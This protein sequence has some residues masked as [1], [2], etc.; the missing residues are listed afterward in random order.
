M[1]NPTQ[2]ETIA[3]V[4][5]VQP[6]FMPGGE[7]PFPDA[8]APIPAIA[9]PPAGRFPRTS[10]TRDRHPDA[11]LCFAAAHPPPAGFATIAPNFGTRAPW[12]G[13]APAGSAGASD[14]G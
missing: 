12:P 10:A 2:R 8:D 7:R 4:V 14:R 1:P 3:G 6:S 13:H 9:H 5:N 11:P